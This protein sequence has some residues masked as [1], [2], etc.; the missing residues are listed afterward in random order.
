MADTFQISATTTVRY[1]VNIRPGEVVR[2]GTVIAVYAAVKISPDAV[3]GVAFDGQRIAV[4]RTDDGKTVRLDSRELPAGSH[5]LRIDEV[6]VQGGGARLEDTVIPFVVI[7]TAAPLPDDAVIHQAARLRIQGLDVER[8][9]LNDRVEGPYIDVFKAEHRK[10][11]EPIHSAYNHRGEPV[12][13]DRELAELAERRHTRY[14]KVHPALHDAIQQTDPGQSIQVAV[15]LHAPDAVRADKPA[16]GQVRRRPVLAENVVLAG[17]AACWY[18]WMTPPARS[19]RRTR[20]ASRSVI[21]A[22]SGL[23]GAALDR[24]I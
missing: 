12:D 4:E 7:D 20:K 14:G 2:R 23:S 22:G 16:K 21:P 1:T 6:W 8:L 18:S 9:A 15:W 19:R 13:L 17:Q 5:T 11:G 10:S 24:A 3:R